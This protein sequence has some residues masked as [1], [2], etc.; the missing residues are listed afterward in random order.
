[1]EIGSGDRDNDRRDSTPW[2]KRID[3]LYSGDPANG[4][5]NRRTDKRTR[6]RKC[7]QQLTEV[8]RRKASSIWRMVW[9][10]GKLR[11]QRSGDFVD[12]NLPTE[13]GRHG[14]VNLWGGKLLGGVANP[15]NTKR[16]CNTHSNNCNDNKVAKL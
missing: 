14:Q 15:I 2:P 16:N 7:L 11:G 5:T 12:D 13:D 10:N 3:L 9:R 4:R 1:M 6:R 8:R